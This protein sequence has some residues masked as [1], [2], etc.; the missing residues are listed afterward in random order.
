[1]R[2]DELA[3]GLRRW[4]EFCRNACHIGRR[5][6]GSESEWKDLGSVLEASLA[7][8]S[9][10]TP[11]ATATEAAAG[12]HDKPRVPGLYLRHVFCLPDELGYLDKENIRHF[13]KWNQH[14][15]K[16]IWYGPIPEPPTQ[17]ERHP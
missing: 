3:S 5:H 1:M 17:P 10:L 16:A 14:K 11:P 2:D 6:F 15:D 8:L 9:S 13:D 4:Y 12:W 7:R